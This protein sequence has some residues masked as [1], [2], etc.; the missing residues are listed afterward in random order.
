MN[1]IDYINIAID[2]SKKSK[3]P[4]GAI[5]VKDNE[6]IGRSDADTV[7]SKSMYSHAEL[8]AIEDA[9]KGNL[10]GALE[11]T[12]MYVSCE[13]CVMCM[14]AILYEK[15]S[16]LVYATTIEDSS[17]YIIKEVEVAVEDIKELT[18][19][20]IQIISELQRNEGIEVLK[21]WNENNE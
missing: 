12:T 7:A 11:E 2:I 14:G 13:P 15:I 20:D 10:Y 4:Y 9:S 1:D 21:K 18:H 5:I 6:I 8:T 16:K 3:Y 17:K 19:S